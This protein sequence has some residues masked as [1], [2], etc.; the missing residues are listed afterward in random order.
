MSLHKSL[1]YRLSRTA[2][3]NVL[4]RKER[5]DVLMATGKLSDEDSVFGLAKVKPDALRILSKRRARERTS[6]PEE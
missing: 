1:I 5:M 6:E 2:K 3:R 4:S